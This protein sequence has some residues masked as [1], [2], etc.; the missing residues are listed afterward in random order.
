[1]AI[2]G[3]RSFRFD[4]P[5]RFDII[6]LILSTSVQQWLLEVDSEEGVGYGQRLFRFKVLLEFLRN[7]R[8]S[9]RSIYLGARFLNH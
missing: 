2:G 1:M 8:A 4:K 3:Q 7:V 6:A 9:A 5:R